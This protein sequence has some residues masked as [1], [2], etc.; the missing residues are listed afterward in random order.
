MANLW[1]TKKG[2]CVRIIKISKYYQNS[3]RCHFNLNSIDVSSIKWH[4][5]VQLSPAKQG[6]V[7]G[8]S[9]V[10]SR[11][12]L[13]RQTGR[14]NHCSGTAVYQYSSQQFNSMFQS[15][16]S[17]LQDS[18]EYRSH[19]TMYSQ[20]YSINHIKANIDHAITPLQDEQSKWTDLPK[21]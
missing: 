18:T 21:N 3:N 7:H 19:C 4:R 15:L 9:A 11:L 10:P 5:P 1:H 8:V 12:K 17:E 20:V 16:L 6:T 2:E 14:A 13:L